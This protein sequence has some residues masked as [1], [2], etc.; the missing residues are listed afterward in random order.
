MAEKEGS[1]NGDDNETLLRD[2]ITRFPPNDFMVQKHRVK[3][4]PLPGQTADGCH[5]DYTKTQFMMNTYAGEIAKMSAP[6]LPSKAFS[7]SESSPGKENRNRDEERISEH[8]DRGVCQTIPCPEEKPSLTSD[9]SG[10]KG[11]GS[12]EKSSK[13]S[14]KS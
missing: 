6:W 5:F 12:E 2:S 13:T 8:D 14:S 7:K 4:M 10:D 1:L 3:G 9:K 11:G